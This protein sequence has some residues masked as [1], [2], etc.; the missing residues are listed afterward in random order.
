MLAVEIVKD[1]RTKVHGVKERDMIVGEALNRGL[2]VFR[3]GNASIRIAPPLIISRRELDLGL[4]LFE[5]SL[6]EVEKKC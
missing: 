6:R 3:G 2:I 4:D 1:K 5:E